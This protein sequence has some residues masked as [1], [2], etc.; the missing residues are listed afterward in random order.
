M[1]TPAPDP[2]TP[3]DDA[4][5]QL[6]RAIDDP[7]HWEFPAGFDYDAAAR[8]F[9]AFAD[10]LA[11][12]CALPRG[13]EAGASIQDAT[14]HDQIILHGPVLRREPAPRDTVL[15]RV[16]NWG[17]L[18]T[19]SDEAALDPAALERIRATLA[20]FGY[21]YIPPAVLAL[22]YTGRARGGTGA[23]TWWVRYFDWW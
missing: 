11:R 13:A 17:D 21:R 3:A 14:F 23:I 2:A 7:R 9:R 19:V 18:A 12:A 4:A 1:G 6:L 20:R 22:P 10:E 8:R 15:L 5:L 16:S